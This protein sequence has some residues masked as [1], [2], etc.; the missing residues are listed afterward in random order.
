MRWLIKADLTSARQPKTRADSPFGLDR[1][2]V[3]YA[4]A[5]QR[6]HQ[7]FVNHH[8]LG[9]ARPEHWVFRMHLH[10][11]TIGRM[12][13]QL[14]RRQRKQQPTPA[15][16]NRREFQHSFKE[17]TIGYRV[18]AVEKNIGPCDHFA[19]IYRLRRK[20]NSLKPRLD[21]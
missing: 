15:D 6:L 2:C 13:C 21:R 8:T 5:F 11:F 20:L 17:R 10:K 14:G 1:R 9:K 3:G 7:A 18:L 16:L 19:E 12:Y 4:L